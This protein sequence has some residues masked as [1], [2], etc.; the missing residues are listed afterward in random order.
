MSIMYLE[1]YAS[2]KRIS[3]QP[4]TGTASWL[5]RLAIATNWNLFLFRKYKLY[6]EWHKKTGTFEK[7][8]KNWRN[9]R[10][11]NYWQ[12]LN[13]CNLHLRDSNPDYQCL[14]ITSCRW[15]P[16]PRMHSFTATTHFKSSRSFVLPVCVACSAECDRVAFCRVQPVA[17]RY[18]VYGTR[19]TTT[20][21]R[22][23]FFKSVH[24]KIVITFSLK[25]VI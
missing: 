11:K 8:N 22:C 23:L 21:L 16:P 19:P 12:K 20:V 25:P 3:F 18:T 14:K 17:S 2:S 5:S 9:S 13:H 6:T 4:K 15:R 7:P 10:K 24:Q 1:A